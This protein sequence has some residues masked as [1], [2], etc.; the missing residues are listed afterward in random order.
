MRDFLKRLWDG[1]M[2][3]ATIFGDFMGRLI[4]T[5]LYFTVVLPFGLGVRLLRDPMGLKNAGPAESF[6]QPRPEHPATL[7][8]A[9]RQ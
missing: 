5:V 8:E 4:L 2:K 1:W 7:E 9:Y 3:I 6:Y